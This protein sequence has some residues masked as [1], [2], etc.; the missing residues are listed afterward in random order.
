MP[1]FKFGSRFEKETREE[2][3]AY[4][5]MVKNKK[6]FGEVA[7]WVVGFWQSATTEESEMFISAL[8]DRSFWEEI[9]KEND[10]A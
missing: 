3:L 4:L 5:R 9:L 7:A 1:D 10:D 2:L 8:G 6:S